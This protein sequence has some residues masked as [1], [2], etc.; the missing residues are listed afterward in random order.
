L[1]QLALAWSRPESGQAQL[2]QLAEQVLPAVLQALPEQQVLLAQLAV[3][4][5]TK[6]ALIP[7]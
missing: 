2:E 4:A 3:L 7:K 5:R 6:L 1:T